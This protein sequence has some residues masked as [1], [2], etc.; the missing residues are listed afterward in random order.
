MDFTVID[1]DI[2]ARS[3]TTWIRC[4][5]CGLTE[6]VEDQPDNDRAMDEAAR[7]HECPP[8]CVHC[9]EPMSI[10]AALSD[11]PNAIPVHLNCYLDDAPGV[12]QSIMAYLEKQEAA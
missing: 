1:K 4:D 8:V 5:D 2:Q 3:S 11:E 6:R 10:G 9:D 7:I 12:R